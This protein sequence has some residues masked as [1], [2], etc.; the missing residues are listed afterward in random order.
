[1]KE[2][3]SGTVT[4]D[5]TLSKKSFLKKFLNSKVIRVFKAVAS[6][7]V[8]YRKMILNLFLFLIVYTVARIFYPLIANNDFIR[9]DTVNI[10][11]AMIVIVIITFAWLIRGIR[12]SI[13]L[14]VDLVSISVLGLN[15][16]T[17]ADSEPIW[18]VFLTIA[19]ILM[20]FKSTAGLI[21]ELRGYLEHR[22][23]SWAETEIKEIKEIINMLPWHFVAVVAT[24]FLLEIIL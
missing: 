4:S 21:L 7:I 14:N 19:L 9:T 15:F 12:E 24:F 11:I 13:S 8:Q 10:L 1:M 3:K 23:K 17:K 2:N 6:L 20:L 18:F 22:G 5:A 16:W